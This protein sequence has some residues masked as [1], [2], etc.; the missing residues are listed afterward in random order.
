MVINMVVTRMIMKTMKIT[1]IIKITQRSVTETINYGRCLK[2]KQMGDVNRKY[3]SCVAGSVHVIRDVNGSE[4][5]QQ[6]T[7]TVR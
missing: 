5:M 7:I 4:R 3:T 6:K 1:A 2:R